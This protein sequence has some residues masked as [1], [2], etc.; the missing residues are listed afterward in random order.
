MFH[1]RAELAVVVDGAEELGLG[2]YIGRQWRFTGGGS[3][4]HGGDIFPASTCISSCSELMSKPER[5]CTQ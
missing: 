4:L 2:L 5:R 3:F 1:A